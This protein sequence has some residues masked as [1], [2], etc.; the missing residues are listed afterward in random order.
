MGFPASGMM[1]ATC[2]SALD[3]S[4][5]GSAGPPATNAELQRANKLNASVLTASSVSAAL[6]CPRPSA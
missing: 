2:C 5:C 4:N 6:Q 1:S 3:Q